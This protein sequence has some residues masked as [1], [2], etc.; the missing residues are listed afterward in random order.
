MINLHSYRCDAVAL[1]AGHD[2]PL[3][4]PLKSFSIE[5]AE[6]LQ[7]QLHLYLVS[8]FTRATDGSHYEPKILAG[9]TADLSLKPLCDGIVKSVFHVLGYH[10]GANRFFFCE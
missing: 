5:K 9:V 3:H 1:I 6:E 10:V 7:Q 8:T 2:Q 4:I